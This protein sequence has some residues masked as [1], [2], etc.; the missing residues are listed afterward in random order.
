MSC[1]K[2]KFRIAACKEGV[3]YL[4]QSIFEK[5]RSDGGTTGNEDGSED[6][7]FVEDINK[8]LLEHQANH[9]HEDGHKH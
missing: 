4:P 2:Y 5:A 3:V 1:E 6:Y 9:T 7:M 8:Y